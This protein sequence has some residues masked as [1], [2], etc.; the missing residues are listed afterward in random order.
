MALATLFVIVIGIQL[1]RSIANLLAGAGWTWPASDVGAN[2]GAFPSPIGTAFW[3]SLPGVL[4]GH[5]DA[6]LPTPTPDG[7][8]GHGLVWVSLAMTEVALLSATIWVG[9][10]AYQRWG[11]G[12]MRGMA[13]A[14]EAE[15]ILGV[16]RLRKVAGI[17]RP[18][19]YKHAAAAAPVQRTAGD[20]TEQTGPQLG[21]GLSPWLLNGRRTKEER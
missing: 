15:K 6:G 4:G 7:L 20:L 17:V 16:T 9:V 21:H 2:A 13:T 14:A 11:P 1:G 8:A 12:R 10:C 19:L 5:A 3:T 18:D